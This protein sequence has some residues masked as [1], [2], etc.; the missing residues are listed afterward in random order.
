MSV[1]PTAW[2]PRE[3]GPGESAVL[4]LPGRPG[5]PIAAV[6]WWMGELAPAPQPPSGVNDASASAAQPVPED[7]EVQVARELLEQAKARGVPPWAGPD[8]LL[9]GV[10]RT[11]LQAELDAEMAA[12]AQIR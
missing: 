10:T 4:C 3:P 1:L 2:I 5:V 12:R 6:V 8:G 11:V 7:L 9:A